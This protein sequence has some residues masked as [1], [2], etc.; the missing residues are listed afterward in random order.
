MDDLGG[1]SRRASW[2]NLSRAAS[3]ACRRKFISSALVHAWTDRRCASSTTTFAKGTVLVAKSSASTP[4]SDAI[5]ATAVVVKAKRGA[6]SAS[7][8]SSG[9]SVTAS[10]KSSVSPQPVRQANADV[11]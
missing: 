3:I 6:A 4:N 11:S 7:E 10:G 5:H 2:Q 1:Y 8:D 9:R